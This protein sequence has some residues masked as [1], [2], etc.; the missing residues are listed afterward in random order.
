[1]LVVASQPAPQPPRPARA[2]NSATKS[3][4]VGVNPPKSVP[5]GFFHPVVQV[6]VEAEPGPLGQHRAL[7]GLEEIA[8]G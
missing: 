1:M 4:W 8:A 2:V 7:I 5:S 3:T 6:D